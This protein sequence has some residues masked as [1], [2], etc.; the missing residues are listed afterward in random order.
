MIVAPKNSATD[1]LKLDTASIET[2]LGSGR[3]ATGA[4]D[5]PI[6]HYAKLALEKLG[7]WAALQSRIAPAENVRV[8]LSYVA[9]GDAPLGIVYATDAASEPRV[10]VVATFPREA[11]P[12]IIYPFAVVTAA[13]GDGAARF[14]SFL[15]GPVARQSFAAR[16]FSP[17]E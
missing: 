10:K 2:A 15:Q 7:L 8:A 6:G 16:G 13:K 4:I 11:H 9:R 1:E 17:F 12:P 14:L 3:I 5:V